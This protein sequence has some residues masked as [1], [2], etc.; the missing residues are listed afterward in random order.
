MAEIKVQIKGDNEDF[1]H[2]LAE[3][4]ADAKRFGETVKESMGDAKEVAA[5][6][7]GESGFGGIA[8]VFS[9]GT[10]AAVAF[11]ASIA[12]GLKTAIE[13]AVD[14]EKQITHL[15]LALGPAQAGLAKDLQGWVEAHSGAMGKVE[16]NMK[17]FFGLIGT[18]LPIERIKA[19][20]IDLQNAAYQLNIPVGDLGDKFVEMAHTMEIPRGFFREFPQMATLARER[21]GAGPPLPPGATA[22]QQDENL[23]A[24]V[25]A[26]GGVNW[27]LNTL[28]P[29]IA[30]GGELS[31]VRIAAQGTT[32]GKFEDINVQFRN[33]LQ[34][35]GTELLPSINTLLGDFKA[36]LPDITEEL[37]SFG[38]G[39]HELLDF[40]HPKKG[41]AEGRQ[42]LLDQLNRWTVLPGEQG[43]GESRIFGKDNI[44]EQIFKAS[45]DLRAAS[46]EHKAAAEALHRAVNPQ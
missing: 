23:A 43:F 29:S 34:E 21:L 9:G 25:K 42:S 7:M 45:T 11:G 19:M 41:E 32:G 17:V 35:M 16:D 6:I 14:A 31:P 40:L 1:K 24:R 44:F 8:K 4:G 38:T 5:D 36:E 10:V 30:P 18:R 22:E 33:A 37:K 46:E 12:E 20:F 39:L 15:G 3:S 26:V 2:K 27:L 13:E 28:L